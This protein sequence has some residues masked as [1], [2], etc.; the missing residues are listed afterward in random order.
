MT[1]DATPIVP[2]LENSETPHEHVAPSRFDRKKIIT[3]AATAFTLLGAVAVFVA[4]AK[5]DDSDDSEE[6]TEVKETKTKS[7]SKS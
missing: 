4:A 2:V 5:S 1:A 6:S 7:T 3:I